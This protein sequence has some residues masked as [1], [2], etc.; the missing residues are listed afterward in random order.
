MKNRS[1]GQP[2]HPGDWHKLC[3]I[4]PPE[5]ELDMPI[6]NIIHMA[7]A[8]G[9]EFVFLLGYLMSRVGTQQESGPQ[10]SS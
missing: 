5:R 9:T 2:G 6:R 3:F 7:S 10:A 4:G 1:L 8:L